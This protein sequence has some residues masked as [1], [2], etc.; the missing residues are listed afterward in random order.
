MQKTDLEDILAINAFNNSKEETISALAASTNKVKL[1]KGE[2]LFIERSKVNNIYA[3]ISGKVTMFRIT[4]E[5]QKRVVY[6]LNAGELLNEVIF[7]DKTA[8]ISC[9]GFE[10]AWVLC[11]AKE[12]LLKLMQKDFDLCKNVID[13]MARKVRRLYRQLKNT[14]PIK[15]DKRVA[16]KLWMLSRDYGIDT[17]SGIQINLNITVTYLA[18]MLGSSRETIS[19]AMKQL[20]QLGL[21]D[22]E[23][24]KIIVK[25]REELAKYF[26]GM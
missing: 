21:I 7:D 3:L 22:Y 11:I 15:M 20:E 24:K 13:S 8:S 25:S 6:I 2:L 1:K 5:G 26:K 19:R 18:D 9:E 23:K 10:E 16:A 12:E 14:V 17:K 4:E